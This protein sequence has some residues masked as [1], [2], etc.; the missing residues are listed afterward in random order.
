MHPSYVG[1]AGPIAANIE[2]PMN[3]GA[4]CRSCED[5]FDRL[6]ESPDRECF[7]DGVSSLSQHELM[8]LKHRFRSWVINTEA[9]RELEYRLL[10]EPELLKYVRESLLKLNDYIVERRSIS[11]TAHLL[12]NTLN[13]GTIVQSPSQPQSRACATEETEI[14]G[15]RGQDEDTAV[16]QATDS[17]STSDLSGGSND[18][19]SPA[20][21]SHISLIKDSLDSLFR[22]ANDICPRSR[23]IPRNFRLSSSHSK[24]E[25]KALMMI[26]IDWETL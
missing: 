24:R 25:S 17:P 20:P 14:P 7:Q 19:D 21:K 6:L 23:Y 18:N 15:F 12:R 16:D 9:H 10:S 3:L 13:L 1:G 8:S 11:P 22:I 5:G 2:A 26:G 4:I